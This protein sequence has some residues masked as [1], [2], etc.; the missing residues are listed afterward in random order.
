MKSDNS[1]SSGVGYGKPPLRTKFKKG[2]SGNP[3]GRPKGSRNIK[4]LFKEKLEEKITVTENGR[5]K[6]I[7]KQ[8]ALVAVVINKALGGDLRSVNL[9]MPI[10]DGNEVS[11]ES[12]F[13]SEI[14]QQLAISVMKRF[15]KQA[16]DKDHE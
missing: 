1:N 9:L 8:E 2:K 12:G 14:D 3:R 15:R 16:E 6:V 13:N 5:R 4:T 10:L 7:S 11:A